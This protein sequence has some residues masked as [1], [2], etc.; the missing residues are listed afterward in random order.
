M[1]DIWSQRKMGDEV[2]HGI[3]AWQEDVR[4]WERGSGEIVGAA[5]FRDPDFAKIALD[6]DERELQAEMLDWILE[7][8]VEKANADE[9]VRL[10]ALTFETSGSNPDLENL[11]SI[12]RFPKGAWLLFIQRETSGRLSNITNCAA[13]RFQG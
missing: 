2:V 6:P 10:K 13:A 12:S 9:A 4:I 8:W 1:F 3:T 11:V 7:R 5:A